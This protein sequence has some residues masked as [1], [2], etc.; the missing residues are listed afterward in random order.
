MTIFPRIGNLYGM[1][2]DINKLT[3]DQLITLLNSKNPQYD[4]IAARTKVYLDCYYADRELL[5]GS[6][7][8]TP[9][10]TN[11]DDNFTPSGTDIRSGGSAYLQQG[12]AESNDD[13]A[14][15]LYETEVFML[16]PRV[17]SQLTG[18]VYD[19]AP[20][21]QADDR[22]IDLMRDANTH[23][24]TYQQVMTHA[25]IMTL[26]C[27]NVLAIVD[28]TKSAEMGEM[29]KAQAYRF[30]VRPIINIYTPE[31]IIDWEFDAKGLAW[32]HVI[33]TRS[34]RGEFFS[35]RTS[36]IVH[37]IVD[38]TNIYQ[39]AMAD[40][41]IER[42][43]VAEHGMSDTPAKF[44][45]FARDRQ[46]MPHGTGISFIKC[47]CRADLAALR[48]ESY[49]AISLMIHGTPH[50]WRR[51]STDEWDMIS[52]LHQHMVANKSYKGA[53]DYKF[54]S[55]QMKVGFT[56]YHV[57]NGDGSEMGYTTLDGTGIDKFRE[58]RNDA[59][60]T[61][62]ESAGFDPA[63]VL[64]SGKQATVQSGVSKALGY[65]IGQGIQVSLLSKA[66]EQF[67]LDILKIYSEKAG[68]VNTDNVSVTYPEPKISSPTSKLVGEYD[69]IAEWGLPITTAKSQE[70]FIQRTDLYISMNKDDQ[71]EVIQEIQ[72]QPTQGALADKMNSD[73][74]DD[75]Q[76][77]GASD[78]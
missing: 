61:A 36:Q 30:G 77:A 14:R 16:T 6:G 49:R 3:D 57:L 58:A 60:E 46:D 78:D 10:Q 2:T 38:R 63:T 20:T 50:L 55:E 68:V 4:K 25:F 71:E 70:A 59:R 44:N 67:D 47:T 17:V 73:I 26:V 37:I 41:K 27:G 45:Y 54:A 62:L 18:S 13:Y 7:A 56:G 33:E 22:V 43:G 24:Q 72:N 74:D 51:M 53:L 40:G 35:G 75:E 15:R 42:L 48:A 39:F 32:V 76:A 66:M 23:N 34:V 19:P 29:S 21:Y 52:N 28:S 5:L 64:S 12:A 1:A 11:S 8:S 9:V 69:V 65:Q 31:N